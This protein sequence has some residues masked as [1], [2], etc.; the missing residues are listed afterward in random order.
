MSSRKRRIEALQKRADHL[1]A[2][3]A[4]SEKLEL[5]FDKQ[6]LG[7]LKWAIRELSAHR[8]EQVAL[9]ELPFIVEYR[10]KPEHGSGPWKAMA[11]FDFDGPAEAYVKQCSGEGVPWEYQVRPQTHSNQGEK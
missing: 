4:S 2:R 11:A 3:I 7:A 10:R 9:N 1:A 6:E 5:T 8:A